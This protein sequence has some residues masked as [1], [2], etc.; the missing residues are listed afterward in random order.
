M[1]SSLLSPCIVVSLLL[2]A[3]AGQSGLLA[4]EPKPHDQRGIAFE[5]WLMA[6]RLFYQGVRDADRDLLVVAARLMERYPARAAEL[7]VETVKGF[8][9]DESPMPIASPLA[10]HRAAEELGRAPFPSVDV[11]SPGPR[12][13]IRELS[14]SGRDFAALTRE[15]GLAE[16]AVVSDD[17]GDLDVWV[18]DADGSPM[19]VDVQAG[20]ARCRWY[21]TRGERYDLV[22]ENVGRA[23]T[24]YSIILR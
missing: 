19:C 3:C 10:A 12:R 20:D 9:G 24:R 8:A 14:P 4:S 18:R 11:L 23:T 15:D 13:S 1:A 16:V 21:A 2:S 7:A 17:R 6:E 22:V 5:S